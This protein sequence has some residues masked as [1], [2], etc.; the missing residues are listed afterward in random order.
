MPELE[1]FPH[2]SVTSLGSS[3][4]WQCH[5]NWIFLLN[6]FHFL[7]FRRLDRYCC[8][9]SWIQIWKWCYLHYEV[10]KINNNKKHLK[11]KPITYRS[12]SNC[13]WHCPC[14]RIAIP[15]SPTPQF[16]LCVLDPASLHCVHF[17]AMWKKP[18]N[19]PIN[20]Y[21]KLS[22]CFFLFVNKKVEKT[23]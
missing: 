7:E 11:R 17:V 22:W 9:S 19:S 10:S 6:R 2:H 15:P 18:Q 12:I 3:L 1:A 23:K 5:G 14:N 4:K 16:F 8:A 21:F 13:L 20:L